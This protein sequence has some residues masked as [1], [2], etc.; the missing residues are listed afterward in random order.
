MWPCREVN[1]LINLLRMQKKKRYENC[2]HRMPMKIESVLAGIEVNA[3]LPYSTTITDS[4][5]QTENWV[6]NGSNVFQ[7]AQVRTHTRTHTVALTLN[8]KS[9]ISM[10]LQ[11]NTRKYMV[12][13]SIWTRRIHATA[14][15][16]LTLGLGYDVFTVRDSSIYY[17]NLFEF[18]CRRIYACQSTCSRLSAC[19]G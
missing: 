8:D 11:G 5:P 15:F 12:V 2:I 16:A 3:R 6:R 4:F 18:E 9:N 19:K 14:L 7:C 17:N 1:R 13:Q 10:R